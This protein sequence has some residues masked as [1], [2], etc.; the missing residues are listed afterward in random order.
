MQLEGIEQSLG[1]AQDGADRSEAKEVCRVPAPP[2]GA[3]ENLV[4]ALKLLANE[5]TGGDSLVDMIFEGLMEQHSKIKI[6]NG[7]RRFTEVDNHEAV[8]IGDQEENSAATKV[9]CLKPKK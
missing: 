9:V 8:K 5:Q 1:Y 3:C 4:C 2:Q 7:P 6:T